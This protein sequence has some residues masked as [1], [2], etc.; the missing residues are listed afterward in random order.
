MMEGKTKMAMV[1]GHVHKKLKLQQGEAFFLF[2]GK[3][4]VDKDMLV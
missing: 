4:L 2:V 1:N 3:H